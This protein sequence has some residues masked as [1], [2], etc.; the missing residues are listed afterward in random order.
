MSSVFV[1]NC[2]ANSTIEHMMRETEDFTGYQE[3]DIRGCQGM[4]CLLEILDITDVYI[5]FAGKVV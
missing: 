3:G 2:I 4:K 5:S 1:F